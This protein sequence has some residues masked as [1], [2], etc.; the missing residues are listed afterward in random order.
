MISMFLPVILLSQ[1]IHLLHIS[2]FLYLLLGLIIISHALINRQKISGLL[3]AGGAVYIIL[4]IGDV[5]YYT[6]GPER[7]LQK[8]STTAPLTGAANRLKINEHLE[9]CYQVYLRYGHNFGIIM[10][11]LDHFKEIN[12]SF[13][14][15]IGDEVLKLVVSTTQ[16]S[17]R[18][19]DLLARWGGEEFIVLLPLMELKGTT[20]AAEKIRKRFSAVW[21]QSS[22][23]LNIRDGI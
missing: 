8:L 3:F 21:I 19:C 20:I 10:F 14:H 18:D 22:M 23:K 1:T 17:I 9:Q 12:D 11:D 16:N 6:G 7:L 4:A 2:I 5:L 13:G 15:Q